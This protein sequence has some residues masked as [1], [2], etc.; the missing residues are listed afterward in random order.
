M[1]SPRRKR[2]DVKT[3]V[4]V[5]RDGKPVYGDGKHE[6]LE[7][8]EEAGSLRAAAEA[9]GMSYRNFWGRLRRMEERLGFPLVERHRGGP[10]G[11]GVRLSQR[12]RALLEAYRGYRDAVERSLTRAPAARRRLD[13]A[14]RP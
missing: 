6:C 13:E 3:R 2:L 9:M 12:G 8:V 1:A 4:W 7:R 14:L 10:G 5:E 11:G